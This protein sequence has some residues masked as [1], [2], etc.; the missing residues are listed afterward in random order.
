[1][2]D[3]WGQTRPSEKGRAGR[4]F[5]RSVC[6]VVYVWKMKNQSDTS[7][8]PPRPPRAATELECRI[9][10]FF[11]IVPA[12]KFGVRRTMYDIFNIKQST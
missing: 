2:D 4:I 12:Y 1:M 5:D 8:I 6:N 7:D 3:Y 10:E 11:L 9:L